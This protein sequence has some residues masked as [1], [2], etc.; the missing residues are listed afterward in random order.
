[1]LRIVGETEVWYNM[2]ESIYGVGAAIPS[3]RQ[4]MSLCESISKAGT[5]TEKTIDLKNYIENGTVFKRTAVRGIIRRNGQFLIIH[6]MKYGDYKFPGGGSHDGEELIDTLV[7]E[8]QEETGY[9]VK[10]ETTMLYMKVVERRKGDP[11][12]MLEMTSW[13]YICDVEDEQGERNLDDYE[14]EYDYRVRW[15]SLEEAIAA[16]ERVQQLDAVPWA[17]REKEV[18]KQMVQDAL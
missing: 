17:V 16:N 4:N 1:M 15:M 11:A 9:H 7:R 8:V 14:E 6:S 5:M 3:A 10:P 13:Y 18:M 12:D 2:R